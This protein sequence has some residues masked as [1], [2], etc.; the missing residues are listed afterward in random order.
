LVEVDASVRVDVGLTV[1]DVRQAVEVQ[2]ETPLIQTENATLSQVVAAR[3]V[4]DMPLNGRNVL[5]LVSLVPGVVPQG[6]SMSNL[7]G[8]NIFAAG[9]YQIGGGTANQSATYL[10]G[11]PLNVNYANL[12]TLVPTQDA[13]AEFRVQTNNN[14]VE[15]G[16]YTGG[17]INLISKS[18]SNS[19]HG[20]GYE[21]L[22]NTVLN[23]TPF[24]S[25]ATGAG[26]AAY[27]QNQ[28]GGN[29]GGPIRK[30]KTFFF[31][32]YEG[33]RERQGIL[34]LE[35]V[36]T[37]AQR[38][39]DFS[40]LR[41]ANGALVPIY[42]ALTNCGTGAN[43]ACVTGQPTRTPFP[44]NIIPADRFDTVAKNMEKIWALP[45]I[46]GQPFTSLKNFS[47]NS[48][49]GG[50]NDQLNFRGDQNVSD[51]QRMFARFTRWELS[52]M[53][54]DPFNNQTYFNGF[55]PEG[56]VTDQVVL[57]NTYSFTP[58]TIGDLRLS[59]L[60]FYYDRTPETLGLDESS[61]GF[62]ASWNSIMP[63]R[64]LPGMTVSG[65]DGGVGQT[66]ISARNNT[67]SIAPSLIKLMGR[68]TLK[69]G[70]ELRR[71]DD[72]FVQVSNAGGLFTFDNLFTSQNP[73][74]PGSTGS[75]FAS[76]LLGYGASGSINI[77]AVTAGSMRYQSYYAN[78][79]FQATSKLTVTLGLRWEIPG[80]WTERYNSMSV[81]NPVLPN[82]LAQPTNLPLKGTL[83][84][85][86]TPDHPERGLGREH[87]KLFAPRLGIA[88]RLSNRTVIRTGGGIFY[89]PA[90]T[91]LGESPYSNPINQYVN[92]WVPSTDNSTTPANRLSNP[93][94]GGLIGPPTRSPNFASLTNGLALAAPFGDS[95][96]GYT[97][98][99]NFT[100]QHEFAGGIAAELGYAG[101]RGQH[102]P[103]NGL[104]VDQLPD[105]LLSLGSQ[106]TQQVTNPFYGLI[107]TG[108]LAQKTVQRGQLLRPFPQYNG[109][110]DPAGYIGTS[111]YHSLQA[112]VEK[113]LSSGGQLLASYTFSK[114]LSNEE[115]YTTWLEATG[116]GFGGFQNFNNMNLEKSLSSFDSRQRFVL[117]YVLDL[118]VGKGQRFLTGVHGAAD[119][120]L[121]G[122]GINGVNT[123][124]DGFPLHFTATPNL[125]NSFG[126]GSRPNVV[127]GCAAQKSGAAQDR[128]TQWFNTACY[129]TPAA[130][131]FGNESRTD[132]LLRGHGINNIDFALFKNTK[133]KERLALQFR[134][135][136]FNLCNR[137]QFAQPAQV[138]SPGISTFGQVTSQLNSPRLVQLAL[139]LTY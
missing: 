26:K 128:L 66:R 124:Q 42:D 84:L 73:L 126:G 10:D 75:G 86:N 7:T 20:T 110:T 135:E 12:T 125:T 101:S 130:F 41:T 120:L 56:F 11:S 17:V 6:H 112:K 5:N 118:P 107:Q 33:Y 34:F 85:V 19:F 137:V 109:V 79:S 116:G 45:N 82:A 132:S 27:H 43:A 29:F 94:P 121:S 14:T 2:A 59:F 61:I 69:F 36:P 71:L 80:V 67:Y 105:Q 39:G 129:T 119:K 88:Y 13:V 95:R 60:R 136:V 35:T 74:S 68:H 15:Y 98:Q 31:A 114:I 23:A 83:V 72:N 106:L 8:Q 49:V 24:F 64:M 104:Q 77:P 30:D 21:F 46:A 115:S 47:K 78:D 102:L 139:R 25:N 40:N 54:Q 62:P 76:F 44:G 65:L 122:W 93:I 32:G 37:V 100:I 117:S 96:Y 138:L 111:S 28:F 131:T 55:P 108:P 92:T 113:R 89:I 123:F 9:N 87:W 4:Q 97:A 57:A 81:F 63:F 38:A 99:W 127:A 53:K 22:R 16:R 51:N 90:D 133:I 91:V 48:P 103:V 18:G 58:T 1:G 52:N 50:N 70:G 3:T 134:A